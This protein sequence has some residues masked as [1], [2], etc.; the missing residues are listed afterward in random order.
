MKIESKFSKI[1][2]VIT[3]LVI[4]VGG[5]IN[6]CK[7]MFGHIHMHPPSNHEI[8]K[9]RKDMNLKDNDNSRLIRKPY[10]E[11]QKY[12]HPKQFRIKNN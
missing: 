11:K 9:I 8:K 3:A 6:F 1:A 5:T 10:K 4:C 2:M 12:E 7:M